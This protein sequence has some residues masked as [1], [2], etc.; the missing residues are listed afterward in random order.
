MLRSKK[1]LGV[2][3]EM[4]VDSMMELYDMGVI[5]NKK[6]SLHKESLSVRLPWEVKT[7]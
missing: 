5:T 2:H 1:D 7:L 6:K 4:M 3:T